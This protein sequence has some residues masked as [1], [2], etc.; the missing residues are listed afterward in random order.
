MGMAVDGEFREEDDD[1][2]QWLPASL[3]GDSGCNQLPHE[4]E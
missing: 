4:D 2:E 1:G 3:T